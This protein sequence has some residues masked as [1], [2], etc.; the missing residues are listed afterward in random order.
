MDESDRINLN[1]MME[2][3][4]N[5]PDIIPSLMNTAKN[6]ADKCELTPSQRDKL[7]P[8]YDWMFKLNNVVYKFMDSIAD[9]ISKK[10]SIPSGL[11]FESLPPKVRETLIQVL[12]QIQGSGYSEYARDGGIL[13]AG[14]PEEVEKLRAICKMLTD[15]SKVLSDAQ[16]VL[17][18]RVAR[19]EEGRVQEALK[20]FISIY[21]E[22]INLK[23]KEKA[24]ELNAVE[25]FPTELTAGLEDLDLSAKLNITI[26]PIKGKEDVFKGTKI[27]MRGFF[28]A[29]G[30]LLN[31][32]NPL[33]REVA[34]Y[35]SKEYL[36]LSIPSIMSI[37]DEYKRQL[38]LSYR[39]DV[40]P[41]FV[42]WFGTQIQKVSNNIDMF[43]KD[44]LDGYELR[45]NEAK[46][47]VK[48]ETDSNIMKWQIMYNEGT[49]L[50]ELA[51]S[52][53]RYESTRKNPVDYSNN[54]PEGL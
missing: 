8:L 51:K 22:D 1:C 16:T 35:E 33:Y 26:I 43:H 23:S 28:D 41:R 30:A 31:L 34:I 5:D 12:S 6:L 20:F 40:Q 32:E 2:I 14:S 54:C 27:E 17:V 24:P 18:N 42:R 38:D 11:L 52:S 25:I 7:V 21:A 29:L 3:D 47:S 45:L 15:L 19:Q 9:S 36:S 53:L 10:E 49:K 4:A 48:E 44:L 13:K 50:G 46:D 39:N 37:Y